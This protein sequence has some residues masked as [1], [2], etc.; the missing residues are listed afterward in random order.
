MI[1]SI[2]RHSHISKS[3]EDAL[4]RINERYSKAGRKA[5]IK[6]MI[7]D[8]PYTHPLPDDVVEQTS[9]QDLAEYYDCYN[10]EFG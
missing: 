6:K 3:V 7:L 4:S 5:R 8:K 1:A 2:P 9:K 10:Y